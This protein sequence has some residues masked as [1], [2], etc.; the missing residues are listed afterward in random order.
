MAQQ[1]ISLADGGIVAP[2]FRL[3]TV[4]YLRMYDMKF[5]K[6]EYE[7]L[8]NVLSSDECKMEAILWTGKL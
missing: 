4:K 3:E 1:I 6:A 2:L 5:T 8:G 7:V